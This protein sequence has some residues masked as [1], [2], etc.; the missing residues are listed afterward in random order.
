MFGTHQRLK[1][2]T[3]L[4]S[5][6][7]VGAEVPLA[8]HVIILGT[9]SDCSHGQKYEGCMSL[10]RASTISAHFV[11]YVA[12]W[13]TVLLFLLRLPLLLAVLIT[14]TLYS[15]WLPIEVSFRTPTVQNALARITVSQNSSFPI[16]STTALLWHSHWLP[17]AGTYLGEGAHIHEPPCL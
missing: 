7:V 17:I 13:T 3:N 6:N 5:F 2:L 12:L 10:S 14:P 1:S 9:I 4:K 11:R 16:R 8:D 15:V